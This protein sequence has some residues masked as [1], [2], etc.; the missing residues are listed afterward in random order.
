MNGDV[1]NRHE[2]VI[3]ALGEAEHSH[4]LP[5]QLRMTPT[6]LI[7]DRFSRILTPD[8]PLVNGKGLHD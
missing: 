1:V 3:G 2:A 7:A 5:N 8:A 4:S 6:L